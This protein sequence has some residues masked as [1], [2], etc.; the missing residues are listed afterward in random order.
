MNATVEKLDNSMVKLTIEVD[1]ARFEEGMK[2]AYNTNKGKL[3]VQGFRKGK[4]PR[5][6]IEKV[7]GTSVFYEDAAN[8]CIPDAY[9][10]AVEE[11]KLEVVS[12]PS[13]D[14]VQIEKG[15]NFIF[16]A[17]V[18]VK[19]EITVADYKGIAVDKF[20]VVVSDEEVDAEIEKVREQNAR[21]IDVTDRAVEDGDD[22]TIDFEGFVDGVAFEGGKGE[23]YALKIGS[24]TFIDTFEDQLVGKS[25]GEDVEVNVTFPEEYQ[26]ESLQGKPALFKV[27]VKSIKAKELPVVDDEF[28]QDISEFDTL[29]AYKSSV[30]ETIKERKLETAK[31][32]KQEAVIKKLVEA[33]EIALPAP[34]VDLE[35]ENM[36]YDFATRLQYQGLNIEQYFQYT[37]QNMASLKESM[38]GQAENKIKVGLVLEAVAKAENLTISDEEFEA[39]MT[40]MAALY[41]MEMDK[42]KEN[43]G[44]EEKESIMQDML[45]QKAM[46]LVVE[47]SVEN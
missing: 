38:K 23:D 21:I 9:D 45:N 35:A 8:F 3:Q 22:T 2:H 4:A 19:P 42:L 32:D 31:K 6:M 14:V 41:S 28:A 18:A 33:T 12:R 7:Y 30:V 29:E 25:I 46:D 37:G 47:A 1:A 39:E 43:I 10:A 24:H 26:Q 44:A 27:V 40:R 20:E 13:V 11:Q 5:Q 34:M 36:T 15:Q 16:T 17:E